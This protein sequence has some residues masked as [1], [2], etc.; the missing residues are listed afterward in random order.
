MG[1]DEAIQRGN[2]RLHKLEKERVRLRK[3]ST[4]MDA[5]IKKLEDEI[6]E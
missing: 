4:L 3:K 1:L 2:L 5:E 6:K